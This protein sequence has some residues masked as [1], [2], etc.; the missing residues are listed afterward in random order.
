MKLKLDANGN[1]VLQDGKPVYI[2]DDGTEIAFDAAGTVATISRLNAEAK[3]HREAIAAAAIVIGLAAGGLGF[4]SV[5]RLK[6]K[7]GYDDSLDAFGVHGI[8][9]TV[10]MLLL[11]ISSLAMLAL[12]LG[13]SLAHG[14]ARPDSDVDVAIVLTDD[15]MARQRATGGPARATGPTQGVLAWR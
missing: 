10:G 1:V 9:S 5:S 8:G 6:H 13:G 14:Y 12:L 15:A 4:F 2:K 7:L 3:G 11:G